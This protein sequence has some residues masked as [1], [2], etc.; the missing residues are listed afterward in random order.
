M[1]I[2]RHVE[3][4]AEWQDNSFPVPF[5]YDEGTELLQ[6]TPDGL[7]ARLGVLCRDDSPADPFE[8]FDE[9]EFYQFGSRCIH[10]CQRPDLDDF[11]RVIRANSGRVFGVFGQGEGYSIGTE[12]LTATEC[13]NIK[14]KGVPIYS[15]AEAVLN[16]IDGYY[17]CP[18][19]ATNPAQYAKAVIDQYTAFCEGDVWGVCIWEFSRPDTGADWELTDRDNECWG[20]YGEDYAKQTLVDEFMPVI[21]YDIQPGTIIYFTDPA[22]NGQFNTLQIDRDGCSFIAGQVASLPE[23]MTSLRVSFSSL[24]DIIQQAVFNRLNV[25]EG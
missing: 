10:G 23:E 22:E 9:G 5:P 20:Y 4:S 8:E 14:E 17:I 16:F 15:Q 25:M 24:P 21:C 1:A 3:Y 11:K 2:K 6:I 12:A 19:D 13:R 7:T 18:A